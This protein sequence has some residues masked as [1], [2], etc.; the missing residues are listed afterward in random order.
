[1]FCIL[2]F[3]NVIKAKNNQINYFSSV[4][5]LA[6]TSDFWEKIGRFNF[7]SNNDMASAILKFS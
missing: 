6:N 2:N 5:S 7:L 1:M 4:F 3:K